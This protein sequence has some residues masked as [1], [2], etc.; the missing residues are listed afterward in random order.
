MES[1]ALEMSTFKVQKFPLLFL[2]SKQY[3]YISLYVFSVIK[4]NGDSYVCIY[5]YLTFSII[6]IWNC[7]MKYDTLEIEIKT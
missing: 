3:I 6:V 5:I 2:L 4:Q 7:G 1:L